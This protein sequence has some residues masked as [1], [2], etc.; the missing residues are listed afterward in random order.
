[1]RILC[2]GV[3]YKTAEVALRERLAFDAEATG[4]ALQELTSRWSEA[5]FVILSTCNRVEV[6]T[7]RPVHGHPREQELQVWLREFHGVEAAECGEA[8]YTLADASAIRHLFAVTSSLDSMVLGEAQ[9]TSQVKAAYSL[10][11]Q[12]S[13]AGPVM[14]DLFQTALHVAKHVRSETDIAAGKVSVASVA[15]DCVLQSL[16][17]PS[18][19]EG[20]KT[21]KGPTAGACVLN[22]G[23]GEMNE[24]MLQH[25]A[26]LA[27]GRILVANRSPRRAADLAKRF[28][29]EAVE[30]ARLGEH[31]AAADVVL[32]STASEAPVI[33]RQMVAE[34]QAQRGGRPLLIV[35][36]AV[37]R[38][39]EPDTR[40]IENVFLYNIDDLQRVVASSLKGRDTQRV[41]AEAIIASHV[42]ESLR[43]LKIRDVAPTIE[44]MYQYMHRIADEELAAA[45]KKLGKHADAE[46][47]KKLL[48]RALH[49]TIRRILHPL[50]ANLRK[51]ATSDAA[52][53]HVA[54]L[55]KLFGLD[56]E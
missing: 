53:V 22:V 9:I 20:D 54:A 19:G 33:T 1:M 16:E 24:L 50:A 29:G 38:D 36:I 11:R 34:A 27:V 42:A 48:T 47:N 2:I 17:G 8:M 4:R 30:F 37:P 23:G 56:K 35:D 7:A 49:R 21:D 12:A 44:A 13:A 10:A 46:A 6:Y 5:E 40:Q 32:S 45:A 26:E 3:N 39:V 28:G 31:L 51:S 14:N 41:A 25:L 18:G 43:E 52:R 55:R 15:V